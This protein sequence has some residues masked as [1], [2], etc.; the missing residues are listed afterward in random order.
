VPI[1]VSKPSD[2]AAPE[3]VASDP[4]R[5]KNNRRLFATKVGGIDR[6]FFT[7][8]LALLLETGM[9]LV[10]SLDLLAGQ[11]ENLAMR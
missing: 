3:A 9:P 5:S 4:A 7:E 1:I 11:C 2:V 8:Q 6:L 10:Q